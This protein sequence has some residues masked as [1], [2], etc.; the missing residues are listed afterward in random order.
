MTTI[1]KYLFLILIS[2]TVSLEAAAQSRHKVNCPVARHQKTAA[3][4]AYLVES[5]DAAPEF[6]GGD[7]ALVR[8]INN[9]RQ[10]PAEA[11]RKQIQG[12]VLCSFIVGTDG[13]LSNIEVVRGVDESLNREAVRIIER[14][15]RWNAGRIGDEAVPV[16]YILPIPFRL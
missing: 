3:V 12:R 8:F 2:L 6:P 1:A 5:V 7:A 15:P 11:Y 10:Y 4:E 16:F 13:S 9:V 14:M